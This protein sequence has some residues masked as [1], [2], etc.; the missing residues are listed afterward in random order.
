MRNMKRGSL[1][2][3]GLAGSL[4]LQSP[5]AQAVEAN[6]PYSSIAARNAFALKPIPVIDAEAI[7][8]ENK[9]KEKEAEPPAK[10]DLTAIIVLNSQKKA[11]FNLTPTKP[12]NSPTKHL[13]LREGQKANDLELVEIRD[14][15]GE[16]RV[17]LQGKEMTLDIRKNGGK[18]EAVSSSIPPAVPGGPPG[19]GGAPPT[20]PGAIN[21]PNNPR[22]RNFQ[23]RIPPPGQEGFAPGT[24]GGLR[25]GFTSPAAAEPFV[26]PQ[27]ALQP[28]LTG[29]G[30]NM[31]VQGGFTAA[32]PQPVT[33]VNVTAQNPG[34]AQPASVTFEQAIQNLEA[35][36]EAN[37]AAVAAGKL[38]P[39]PPLPGSH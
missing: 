19:V 33:P 27:S 5:L 37:A 31:G 13:S 38:P 6:N 7:A 22:Q 36:R 4:L 32:V 14:R 24:E 18:L 12:A 34:G 39:Y 10:I 1:V 16:V 3:A 35:N 11:Y 21:M 28:P 8:R 2:F 23:G 9:V 29:L 20:L 15:A 30:G 25:P 26:E 17:V